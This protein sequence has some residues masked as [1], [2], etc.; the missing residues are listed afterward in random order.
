VGPGLEGII[1]AVVVVALVVVPALAISARIALEPIA[2]MLA[3][4][5][6]VVR[7]SG[8]E[9]LAATRDEQVRRRELEELGGDGSSGTA[10]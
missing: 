8:E 10:S 6:E 9:S 1:E 5:Y 2:E 4:L 3:S 7:R